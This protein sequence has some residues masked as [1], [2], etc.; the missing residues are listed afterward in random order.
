[1]SRLTRALGLDG[2]RRHIDLVRRGYQPVYLD[3]PVR[4][5]P[6]WG[7]G[8]PGHTA[9][10]RVVE[11][12]RESCA[13]LLA[14]MEPLT[15]GLREIPVAAPAR[16]SPAPHWDN[17]YIGSLDAVT[18]STFPKLFGTRRYVEVGSGNSTK[19]VRRGAREL[20]L[21]LH[22]TSIDPAPRAEIDTLCDELV[23]SGLEQTA[24]E[25]FEEL[26]AG[27]VLMCDGSHRCLQ[28]S[29]VTAFFLDVLPRLRPGVLVYVDDVYLPHDYPPEWAE[30]F[31]SEQ[32]LLATLLLADAG[33][34]YEILFPAFFTTLDPELAGL[35]EGFWRRAAVPGLSPSIPNGF[36]M[37]VRA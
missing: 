33:R 25:R 21:D 3:Y 17:G 18:L 1:M 30:R 28:H 34:R 23:R 6:R 13:D 19:F 14:R 31:Y 16:P 5:L 9:L 4:P 12:A 29:D 20:G 32:Y 37:R 10:A 8:K 24:P 35:V 27:D 26:E 11:G 7:W 2:L 15:R 36:W 22:I